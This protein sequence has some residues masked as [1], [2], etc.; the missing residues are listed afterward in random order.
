[1]DKKPCTIYIRCDKIELFKVLT[2]I[3]NMEIE[4]DAIRVKGLKKSL[5]AGD[6]PFKLA[7]EYEG[8][9]EENV[10]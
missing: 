9:Y 5:K 7:E 3:Q 10:I 6:K 8:K 4:C 1:M 2:F